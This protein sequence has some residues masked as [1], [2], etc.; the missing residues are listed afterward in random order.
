MKCIIVDDD[1]MARKAM[2][3]MVNATDF[4]ELKESF[5]S[6]VQAFQYL[7][8]N[9]VDLLFLDIEMPEMTGLEMLENM[10]TQ[11]SVIFTTGKKDYALDVFSHK[12]ID[13]LV[14]PIE[15]SK[16]LRAA[17]KAR[18]LH[19]EINE[20]QTVNWDFVL[21]RSE[22]VFYKIF[23]KNI[24]FIEALGDYIHIHTLDKKLILH[25]TMKTFEHKLPPEFMRVHRSFIINTGYLQ[26]IEDNTIAMQGHLIPVGVSYR[27]D[28][29]KRLPMQK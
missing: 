11:P 16:F 19:K 21:I 9:P 14:K 17:I 23:Y 28:L 10:R 1:A 4:L 29:Y 25:T 8:A 26:S 24:I 20:R 7:Q 2:E 3:Q 15:Y 18:D 6:P 27:E 13:Y 12:A 22:G 5:S